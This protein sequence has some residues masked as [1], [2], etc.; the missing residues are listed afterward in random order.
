MQTMRMVFSKFPFRSR[1][2]WRGLFRYPSISYTGFIISNLEFIKG[3]VQIRT[4]PFFLDLMKEILDLR[5][6][7][8]VWNF[9]FKGPPYMKLHEVKSEPQNRRISNRRMSK[10]GF[11]SLS[12]FYKID[13]STKRLT[14]GRIHS[15]DIRHS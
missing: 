5:F 2:P 3:S 14:T 15:F 6:G 11:A 13:R 7:I 1:I 9:G 12:L 10:G 8:W 4:L